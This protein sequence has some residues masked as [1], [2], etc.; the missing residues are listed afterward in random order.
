[1]EQTDPTTRDMQNHHGVSFDEWI[2]LV[3]NRFVP[4]VL[5][6]IDPDGFTGNLR[7][8]V[9]D[10]T[11]VTD[12][13]AS[14]HRVHRAPSSIRDDDPHHLK[15]SM[16]L[17]GTGLVMQDGRSAHLSPGDVAIYDTARPYTLEYAGQMRSL[18]M[19]FP[20]SMLGLSANLVPTV[21]AVRLRG[22][23]GIGRVICPF[24]QHLAEDLDQLE[25][26]NGARIIR[27]A[28]D[29]IT[30][31][32]SAELQS[33]TAREPWRVTLDAV[34]HYIDRHLDDPGLNTDSIAR[35]HFISARQL[36][37][38]FQEEGE[39]VSGYIRSRRLERCRLDLE[40]AAQSSRSI[41]QIAQAWGFIDPSHFSKLFKSTYGHGPRDHRLQHVDAASLAG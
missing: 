36:Q 37:Y 29:L 21:T 24:M 11:C 31:L 26:V 7:T 17:T 20:H 28:F 39:T 23:T 8:R 13:A 19:M 40:D 25:G 4:L 38:L 22:D 35:A 41:V 3:G 33:S 30:A 14:S 2:R 1:M 5:S 27:S 9:V 10:G 15:L 32:L 34:A 12:I 18:V 16:Q 6:T